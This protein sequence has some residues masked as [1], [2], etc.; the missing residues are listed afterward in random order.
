MTLKSFVARIIPRDIKAQIKNFSILATE[1]G[2]YKT[3][4]RGIPCDGDNPLPWD[5][6]PAI[7]YLSQF[8]FKSRTVYEWGSGNS[9]AF[10]AERAKHVVSIEHNKSWYD[11]LLGRLK[12]NQLLQFKSGDSYV[13]AIEDFPDQFDI[14]IVDGERRM[15]CARKIVSSKKFNSVDGFIVFDNSDWYPYTCAYL[16]KALNLIQVDFH[17]FGPINNYTWTTSLLL[18]RGINLLELSSQPVF[19]KG[20]IRKI[21]GDEKNV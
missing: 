18:S 17:G 1:Y 11:M 8:D 13:N 4:Q 3:I 9:S 6:Y 10:W 5:T 21:A 15:E 16:R 19:S 7:E 20:A 2:Q 14:V 12:V